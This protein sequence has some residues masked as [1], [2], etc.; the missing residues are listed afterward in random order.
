MTDTQ[1]DC[2]AHKIAKALVCA[3][4]VALTLMGTTVL[5]IASVVVWFYGEDVLAGEVMKHFN[6]IQKFLPA[7]LLEGSKDA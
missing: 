5:A 3:V 4:V 1:K 6:Y 7:I 2:I